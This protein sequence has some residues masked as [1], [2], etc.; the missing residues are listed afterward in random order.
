VTRERT[1][2]PQPAD[3]VRWTVLL[4]RGDRFPGWRWINRIDAVASQLNDDIGIT[5]VLMGVL[6]ALTVPSRLVR[7]IAYRATGQT[8]WTVVVFTGRGG[9]RYEH[10]A[11]YRE[12]CADL[13]A[14]AARGEAVWAVLMT[15]DALPSG[16]RS[17]PK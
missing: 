6:N 10:D 17:E 8:H 16:G 2:P 3:D 4:W 7:R 12:R 9:F 1:V 11:A 15:D 14:A 13:E 5:L